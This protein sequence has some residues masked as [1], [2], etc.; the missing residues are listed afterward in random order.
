MEEQ[1]NSVRQASLKLAT[2]SLEQ[3]NT[4]LNHLSDQLEASKADLIDANQK[5]LEAGKTTL[6]LAMLS[7]LVFD[8]KKIDTLIAGISDIAAMKDPIGEVTL[9]REIATG[10]N[11]SRVST[12]LGVICVIFESRPDVAFQI[13]SLLLKSGNAGVLKGGSEAMHTLSAIEKVTRA[14]TSELD[15]LPED[16]TLFLQTREDIHKLLQYDSLIDLVIPRGS[17]QLV[18]S[19]MKSTKIPVLGHADGICHIYL[20]DDF[21]Q[22]TALDLISNS[23]LQSPGTCNALETLLV[24]Q[25]RF[26]VIKSALKKHSAEIQLI[27][28]PESWSTEYGNNKL[29]IKS[30]NSLKAAIDHI[31]TFGS[32]HTDAILSNKTE[33]QTRFCAEVDSGNVF[34]NC[35]TRFSDGFRYGFGAEIGISTSKIHARGPVGLEGLVS[36]K[37]LLKGRGHTV[38]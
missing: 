7:R 1:L 3:R 9:N 23:K 4:A 31:N 2:L 28:N 24:H 10:L 36:Y 35:S 32:H 13:S 8:E 6:S 25:S 21:D 29:A 19:I 5:D 26:D 20:S 16:W 18:Q 38:T 30:V 27:E 15:F 37:Y 34:V 12:P 11:L 14:A 22:S 17:N 33:E